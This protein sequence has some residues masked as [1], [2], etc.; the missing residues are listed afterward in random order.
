MLL[1]HEVGLLKIS[2]SALDLPLGARQLASLFM[3]LQMLACTEA[4]H[5]FVNHGQLVF[6]EKWCGKKTS[7]TIARLALALFQA[8][9]QNQCSFLRALGTSIMAHGRSWRHGRAS[10]GGFLCGRLYTLYMCRMKLKFLYTL[11]THLVWQHDNPL[12]QAPNQVTSKK[13]CTVTSDT[14]FMRNNDPCHH[15]Y[16]CTPPSVHYLWTGFGTVHDSMTAHNWEWITEFFQTFLFELILKM[17]QNEEVILVNR[18]PTR[19]SESQ[20]YA[21]R[22]TAGPKYFSGCHQ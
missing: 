7:H 4:H 20:R 22:R 15:T 8:P 10:Y 17:R 6:T 9:R 14:Q 2:P 5:W 19:L 13:T 11:Q 21:W 3:Y 16:V 1:N 18:Q 12:S